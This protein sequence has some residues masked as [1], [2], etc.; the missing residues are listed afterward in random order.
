MDNILGDRDCSLTL[1]GGAT[2]MLEVLRNSGISGDEVLCSVITIF[3]ITEDAVGGTNE[4]L[5]SSV[6]FKKK[7]IK[8]G[9]SIAASGFKQR[10]AREGLLDLITFASQQGRLKKKEG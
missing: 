1:K 9:A 8:L 5:Y 2:A 4:A 10:S 7:N 3:S 6:I